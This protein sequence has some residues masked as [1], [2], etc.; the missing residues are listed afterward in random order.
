MPPRPRSERYQ[1]LPSDAQDIAPSDDADMSRNSQRLENEGTR[2]SLQERQYV[3][4]LIFKPPEAMGLIL[5]IT[6]A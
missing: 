5:R 2:R 1:P 4:P 6:V 3:I